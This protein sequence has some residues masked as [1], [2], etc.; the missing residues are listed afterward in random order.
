MQL[1]N[2]VFLLSTYVG[3]RLT[4]GV[5]NSLSFFK[6][7]VAPAKPHHPPIP[8][9]LKTFYMVGNVI[10]NSLNFFW[11]RA[12][13]RA[14]QKRFTVKPTP[15]SKNGKLDAQ[16]VV[17]GQQGIK[18]GVQDKDDEQFWQEAGAKKAERRSRSPQTR[19]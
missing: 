13:V 3:A 12:M 19:L 16:K 17:R 4:F 6:F 18:L 10:L 5:Y 8:L 9:H 14:V 15:D 1:V 7:V 11:F 2:A